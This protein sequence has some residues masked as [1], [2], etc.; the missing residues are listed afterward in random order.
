MKKISAVTLSTL[1][2][3]SMFASGAMADNYFGVGVGSADL[4]GVDDSSFKIFGGTRNGNLGFEVAYH[5]FGKPEESYPGLY[6]AS[7]EP[8]GIEFSGVGYMPVS[9]TMDFFGKIGLLMWDVDATFTDYT[10]PVTLTGSEDGND[11][12]YGVGLQ[13]N[14]SNNFSLRVEY[15]AS[16]LDVEGEDIDLENWSVGATFKF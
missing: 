15:Q 7:L 6:Y 16:T 5:D 12:I 8:T 11:L 9:P 4:E 1:L 14:S 13:F 2:A 3:S 10:V